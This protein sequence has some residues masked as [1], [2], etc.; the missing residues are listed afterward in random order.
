MP[1]GWGL[2]G[3]AH[4]TDPLYK[5]DT[6]VFK[7]IQSIGSTENTKPC[8]KVAILSSVWA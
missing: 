8:L 2:M 5:T 7:Q 3:F 4:Y 1:L 6:D